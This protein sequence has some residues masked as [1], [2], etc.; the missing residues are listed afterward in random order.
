MKKDIKV[1]GICGREYDD[2]GNNAWPFQAERCCNACNSMY[3]TPVRAYLAA[4]HRSNEAVAV[5]DKGFIDLYDKETGVKVET[6]ASVSHLI[7]VAGA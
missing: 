3:V 7:P 1:C 2:F 4:I 6:M 5:Y